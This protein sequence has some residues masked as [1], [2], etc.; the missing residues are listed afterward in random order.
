MVSPPCHT[1]NLVSRA[2]LRRLARASFG[3]A[4]R[5]LVE[6]MERS[7]ARAVEAVLAHVRRYGKGKPYTDNVIPTLTDP[8]SGGATNDRQESP[9]I[10]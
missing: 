8:K 3:R 10:S 5:G 2:Y 1:S 4:D 7:A 6:E 9:E